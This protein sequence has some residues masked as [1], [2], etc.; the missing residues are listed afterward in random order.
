MP[1]LASRFVIHFPYVSY[2][3]SYYRTDSYLFGNKKV[4]FSLEKYGQS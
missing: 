1:K 4:F 2:Y 3:S